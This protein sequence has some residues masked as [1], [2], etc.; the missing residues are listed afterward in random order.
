MRYG[1]LA[2]ALS[3]CAALLA[4][5]AADAASLSYGRCENCGGGAAA[6]NMER[7]SDVVGVVADGQRKRVLNALGLVVVQNA[8]DPRRVLNQDPAYL[9]LASLAD[10]RKAWVLNVLQRHPEPQ[11]SRAIRRYY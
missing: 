2:S 9:F 11:A 3:L 7:P 10:G 4:P 6:F 1:R 5:P 8:R